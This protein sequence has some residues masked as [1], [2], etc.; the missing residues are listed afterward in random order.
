LA[1]EN[2]H[3]I[4]LDFSNDESVYNISV[5]EISNKELLGVKVVSHSDFF[6]LESFQTLAVYRKQ[7]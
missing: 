4:F 5:S 2:K 7:V 1:R 3:S 6:K